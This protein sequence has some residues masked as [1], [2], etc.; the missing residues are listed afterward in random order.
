MNKYIKYSIAFL[1]FIFFLQGV[2]ESQT[3][4]DS[5]IIWEG[6]NYAAFTSLSYYNG[7]F[8]CAFRE[9]NSHYDANGNNCG[10]IRIIRSKKG[11]IWR[12]FKTIKIDGHDLRDPQLSITPAGRLILLMENVVYKQGKAIFRK[13]CVAFIFPKKELSELLPISYK[14]ALERNWLWNIEWI[15]NIAYGFIYV[16][17]FALV[18]STDGLNYNIVRKFNLKQTPSEASV[19]VDNRNNFFAIARSEGNAY[20]GIGDRVSGEWFWHASN[21]KIGCPKI[22]KVGKDVYVIGRNMSSKPHTTLFKYNAIKKDVEPFIEL[23]DTGDCSY[24]GIVYR[25]G[26]LFISHYEG[27]GTN[28]NILLT[29]IKIK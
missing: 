29:K 25:K 2:A 27:N 10:M 9:G 24:P 22:I 12:N 20:I 6:N 14:P 4:T 1:I 15:D 17:F 7:Y 5:R 18:K 8:Y 19:I 28:S 23:S 13:S 16:P 11:K 26:Y 21:Y 3:I